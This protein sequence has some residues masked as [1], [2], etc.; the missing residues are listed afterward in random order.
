MAKCGDVALSKVFFCMEV[1]KL[2]RAAKDFYGSVWY[3]G[4]VLGEVALCAV[5]CCKV[6]F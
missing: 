1:E 5:P 2:F 4:V 3:G 6:F